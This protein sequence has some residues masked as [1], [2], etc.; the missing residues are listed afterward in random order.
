[1]STKARA[2]QTDD[3]TRSAETLLKAG[4]SSYYGNDGFAARI[5]LGMAERLFGE[6]GD[7][8]KQQIAKDWKT[9]AT[10]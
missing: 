5:C 2:A 7:N 6:S 1:V 4:I 9:T 8:W 3:A 10:G